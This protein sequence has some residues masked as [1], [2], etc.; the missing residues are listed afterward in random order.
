MSRGTT[1]LGRTPCAPLF[2]SVTG[3]PG[4]VLSAPRP[5]QLRLRS[6]SRPVIPAGKVFQPSNFPL[7]RQLTDKS[8]LH[9]RLYVFSVSHIISSDDENVNISSQSS[10]CQFFADI[11]AYPLDNV[12]N[13][14]YYC[15]QLQRV[16]MI[17]KTIR[18]IFCYTVLKDDIEA[19]EETPVNKMSAKTY[20]QL[21]FVLAIAIII[22]RCGNSPGALLVV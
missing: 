10:A 17:H 16:S 3:A 13:A 20:S 2:R 8:T 9:H 19:K 14:L 15:P 11:S 1:L 7:C 6:L 5:F 18:I 4:S 22:I 21:S 12:R